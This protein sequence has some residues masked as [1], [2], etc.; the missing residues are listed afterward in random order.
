MTTK[1]TPL[2]LH[3]YLLQS[4]IYIYTHKQK[5]MTTRLQARIY[6]LSHDY[7]MTTI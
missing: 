2:P 7:K 4:Y 3:N 6:W 1:V 5:Y